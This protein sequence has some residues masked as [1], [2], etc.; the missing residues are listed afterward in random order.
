MA[1]G[2]HRQHRGKPGSGR[3]A[4]TSHRWLS[5]LYLTQKTVSAGEKKP[6][7]G[8]MEATCVSAMIR[9]TAPPPASF[10]LRSHGQA[11]VARRQAGRCVGGRPLC[12]RRESSRPFSSAWVPSCVMTFLRPF[13][14]Q[15]TVVTEGGVGEVT[16]GWGWGFRLEVEPTVSSASSLTMTVMK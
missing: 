5:Q 12:S 4:L 16:G 8:R 15:T 3:P 6:G 11:L 2:R 9:D 1:R 10:L 7:G 13:I 14:S